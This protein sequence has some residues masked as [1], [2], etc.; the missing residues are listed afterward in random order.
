MQQKLQ[1]VPE[2]AIV[3]NGV[4]ATVDRL[5]SDEK[6]RHTTVFYKADDGRPGQFRLSDVEIAAALGFNLTMDRPPEFHVG[7]D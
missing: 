1:L 5:K 3:V 4:A 6:S 7:D 2:D